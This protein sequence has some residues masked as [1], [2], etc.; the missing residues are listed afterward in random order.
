MQDYI[1]FTGDEKG[2]WKRYGKLLKDIVKTYIAGRPEAELHENGLLWT[3][4]S[5]VALSWM[6]AYTD[7]APVTERGGYQVE[8]NAVWYNALMFIAEMEDKFSKGA[9]KAEEEKTIAARFKENFYNIF[10]VPARKHL[11][12]Y[13]G[14]FGQ[15]V[16][17]RP[18]Q[19]YACCL[20]YSPIDEITQDQVLK[21]VKRELVTPRGVRTLAPKNPLFKEVYD[22]SQR[23]R[24]LAYHNGSTRPWLLMPYVTASFKLYGSSFIS[25]AENL[26]AGF[27]DDMTIHGIGAIAEIYD[28]TPPYNPHGAINSATATAAVLTVKY[29]INKYKEVE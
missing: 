16:S 12:D 25:E 28:A 6:N 29:L 8:T 15:D 5:G 21:A 11:A 24:D 20:E 3:K 7:G 22:G 17:T 4:K 2:I 18:N 27:E 23:D 9:N 10:W 26:I 13:V 1:N 19:L 14:P